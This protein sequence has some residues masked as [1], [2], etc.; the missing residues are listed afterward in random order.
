[1]KVN[2]YYVLIAGLFVA[3]MFLT[4]TFFRGTGHA[5]VGITNSSVY[6]LSSEKSALVKAIPVVPGQEVKKGQLLVELSSSELEISIEKLIHRISVLQS[7]LREKAK[8]ADSKIALIKAENGIKVEELNTDIAESEKD[9]SL[10]RQIVKSHNIRWDSLTE[11]PV[12][13][14]SKP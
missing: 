5:S 14:R 3:M 13:Q 11:Q 1:M 2:G 12:P 6:K 4:V 7:D 9:L 10:N 8:L